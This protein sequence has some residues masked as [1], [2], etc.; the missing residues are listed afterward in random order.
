[1]SFC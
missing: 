1:M